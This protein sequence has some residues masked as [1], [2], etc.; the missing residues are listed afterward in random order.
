[1]SQ[2][3]PTHSTG[4]RP[5]DGCG[6]GGPPL[7]KP[8]AG[9]K[10]QGH[11][12][13][14]SLSARRRRGPAGVPAA[15]LPKGA[16][17]H[18]PPSSPRKEEDGAGAGAGVALPI[19]NAPATLRRSPSAPSTHE[20][21]V[22]AGERRMA[23]FLDSI[24]PDLAGLE[25]REPKTPPSSSSSEATETALTA[26]P[27]FDGSPLSR[28]A[29]EDDLPVPRGILDAGIPPTNSTDSVTD[30]SFTM[31]GPPKNN[32]D[33]HNMDHGKEPERP[34]SDSGLGTSVDETNPDQWIYKVLQRE[35]KNQ[36]MLSLSV[37][38]S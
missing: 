23:A 36:G 33:N 37:F 9:H 21:V 15:G 13:G 17:F 20:E 24:E 8:S 28:A 4:R 10:K 11:D 1:M 38:S 22:A 18:T 31:D 34:V 12:G 29:E 25:S 27:G 14:S 16:T 30:S 3:P 32:H 19:R 7:P 35:I 2:R 5:V 26:N 6:A